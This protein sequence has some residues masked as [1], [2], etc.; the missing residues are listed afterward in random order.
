MYA[1]PVRPLNPVKLL[2]IAIASW[3]AGLAAYLGCLKLAWGQSIGAADLPAVLFWSAA[4]LTLAIAVGYA[5]MMFALRHRRAGPRRWWLFPAVG[6]AL[7]IVPVLLIVSVFQGSPLSPE[8]LLFGSMF[9]AS[10]A[11]F[12]TGF[13]WAYVR[14]SA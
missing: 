1:D 13:Y 2:A 12:G 14:R 5:P 9:S 3:V 8:G 7:G 10:G 4:G 11:V 6:V